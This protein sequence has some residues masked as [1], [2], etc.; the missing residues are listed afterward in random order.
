MLTECTN[1]E[2]GNHRPDLDGTGVIE[3]FAEM[4]AGD[5]PGHDSVARIR[6]RLYSST[7]HADPWS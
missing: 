1:L 4:R 7:K 6:R 5:N 3:E 2:D